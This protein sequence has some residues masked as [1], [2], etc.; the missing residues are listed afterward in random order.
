MHDSNSLFAHKSA[1][2]AA[3]YVIAAV[4]ITASA[5]CAGGGGSSG[6]APVPMGGSQSSTAAGPRWPVK[7]R[8]H[9]DLW[10]HAFALLQDDTSRVPL[11]RRNYKDEVTV[12]K[13]R[14]Q[15]HTLLDSNRTKLMARFRQNPSLGGA[16]FAAL[17]FGNWEDMRSAIDLFMRAE[18]DPR[19]S[20]NQETQQIVAFFAAQFPTPADRE[21]LRL[22]TESL[23]DEQRRFYHA[24]WVEEQRTRASALSAVDSL[25]KRVYLPKFQP[26]LNNT[27]QSSGDLVLSLTLGGEGRTVNVAKQQNVVA[28]GFPVRPADAA[29]VIYVLAHEAI[30]TL[31][32][33]AVN[34]NTTP[35]E[36]RNGAGDRLQSNAAVRGGAML[37]QRLA[38]ELVPGYM[39]YYVRIVNA[40]SSGDATLAFTTAFPLTEPVADAI[41]R[42]LDIVLGGI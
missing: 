30:G 34:D 8:E 21:W 10:L 5:A 18:G 35:A 27:Q 25:W 1:R 15:V 3:R 4:L 23:V 29:E 32:G 17:Y 13:N 41:K 33:S 42:Q 14:D 37:L 36:K 19:R 40:S 9:V 11:F 22:L 20:G 6:A 16:Q 39:R 28:V 26:F 24:Y 12:R 2:S 7:T 31:A 38:P